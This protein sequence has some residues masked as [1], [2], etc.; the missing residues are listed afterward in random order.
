M[1]LK[2]LSDITE[3]KVNENLAGYNITFSQARVMNA[4]Y[5]SDN[6]EYTYKELERIFHV[7]CIR[8]SLV[9]DRDPCDLVD[10]DHRR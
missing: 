2:V 4:L 10:I 3:K 8:C 9:L 5:N 1:K 6:D 7:S